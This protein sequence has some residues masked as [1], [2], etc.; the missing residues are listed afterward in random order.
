MIIVSACLLGFT[1]RYDGGSHRD[2]SLLLPPLRKMLIPVCPEQM[3]GLPTP[4]TPSEIHGGDGAGVLEG[5]AQVITETG[6]DVTGNFLRGAEEVLRFMKLTGTS[7]AIMTDK[8]PS[9]GVD[10][11][12]KRGVT[13]TGT[14]VTS[15]LIIRNGFEVISSE[16][17]VEKMPFLM[18]KVGGLTHV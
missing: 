2:E 8:S 15:A 9:C 1:C 16:H 10:R 11:I 6:E 12:K 3:G 13:V 7:V 5:T 14:G 17:I 4:R 18:C